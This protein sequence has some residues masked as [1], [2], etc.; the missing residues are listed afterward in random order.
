VDDQ[1]GIGHDVDLGALVAV[2]PPG[3]VAVDLEG[4]VDE[5]GG[6]ARRGGGVPDQLVLVEEGDAGCRVGLEVGPGGTRRGHGVDV[7]PAAGDEEG[8]GPNVAASGAALAGVGVAGDEGHRGRPRQHELDGPVGLRD[9]GVGLDVELA[10]QV[11][12]GGGDG[13]AGALGDGQP[14]PNVEA[15]RGRQVEVAGRVG[16]DDVARTARDDERAAGRDGQ[17]GGEGGARRDVG[18]TLVAAQGLKVSSDGGHEASGRV[19]VGVGISIS[20]L[21]WRMLVTIGAIDQEAAG[22]QLVDALEAAHLVRLH[23][24]R[25]GSGR[26]VHGRVPVGAL[27]RSRRQEGGIL[28]DGG[29]NRAGGPDDLEGGRRP[30]EDGQG[31][32]GLGQIHGWPFGSQMTRWILWWADIGWEYPK[33]VQ[34]AEPRVL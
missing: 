32:G 7:E 29:G 15:G 31:G 9:L 14:A 24:G 16:I 26:G 23:R 20:V 17:Q 10:L 33:Q 3:A 22:A 18:Q 12:G 34:S 4:V 30:E 2:P 25:E 21:G 28:R 8:L 13:Q 19:S 27:R 11:D 1:S 5:V 6:A